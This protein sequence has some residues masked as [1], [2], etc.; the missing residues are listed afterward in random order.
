MSKRDV[1]LD[2][3]KGIWRG[4]DQNDKA[5]EAII[6]K[7]G[8]V[9]VEPKIDGCRAIVGAHGVVS[10]S[11]RRFPALDGLE[12]RIIDRLARPGL[13]SGLVLDCE[14]YLAGMPF[15][16]ATGR[17]SSKTPLTEEELECL[18]FAVFDATHI[19]VLRKARTSHLVYEE[20]RAMASSLLAACRLSDTPTFFQVGFSICRS[21]SDV[22]RQYKFNR[23]V[24]YEGSMEKDPSLVYRN[25]KVSGCYKRKPEITVDG[26]IVGYVMGKTGKNVGRVVGYRVELEDGSGTVAA[27]GLSEEH[28][29]L[30]TCAHLNAHIDE[31]MPNYGRIVE[32]SA[33]ERSANT[34][35]HPSF[36]RF[37]DLA[38]NP[39]VKV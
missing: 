27:T 36:S 15:S 14:M 12:D 10:R 38:S 28:I 39:G 13:D 5:V 18:H 3:E 22:Y 31:A 8:Y 17:M 37:R 2:I 20:R 11:G 19:D 16:E 23:E 6:K 32:V 33:M 29:Q 30:L 35:R 21:M 25:G 26:R 7:H 34:L 9:I 24:G 4:V 1:V